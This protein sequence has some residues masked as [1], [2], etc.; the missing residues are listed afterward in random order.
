VYK[1]TFG[2]AQ[3]IFGI[4]GEKGQPGSN[5]SVNGRIAYF[6]VPPGKR[7]GWYMTKNPVEIALLDQE[8]MSNHPNIFIDKD[9]W[10]VTPEMAD[11]MM[12][13]RAKIRAEIIAEEKARIELISDPN[14]DMGESVQG[15]LNAQSTADIAPTAAGGGP[16]AASVS[17]RLTALL[18]GAK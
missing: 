11:P 14:R 16:S 4:Y 2:S 6:I 8:V 5:A 18:H 13:L 12:A 3:Y 1:H 9:E 10:E 17:S 15:K 7:F